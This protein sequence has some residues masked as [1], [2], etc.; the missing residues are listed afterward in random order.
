MNAIRPNPGFDWNMISW[1]GPDETPSGDCSYCEDAIPDDCAPLTMWNSA[2]WAAQF[3]D[4][5]AAAWFGLH[6][7]D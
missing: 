7:S 5:C 2:G 3:C 6:A 4:H 1:G